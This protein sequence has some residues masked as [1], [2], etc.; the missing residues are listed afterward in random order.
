MDKK[1][2]EAPDQLTK[3]RIL[4]NNPNAS[5]ASFL[6]P[7]GFKSSAKEY[8][9]FYETKSPYGFKCPDGQIRIV[10]AINYYWECLGII[11]KSLGVTDIEIA[12]S[13]LTLANTIDCTDGSFDKVFK[14][15]ILLEIEDKMEIFRNF[16][17]T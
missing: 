12:E 3:L 1:Y 5:G 2:G 4:V 7:E 15:S 16:N 10:E 13:A 14:D 9:F 6:K 8:V 11:N 17:K